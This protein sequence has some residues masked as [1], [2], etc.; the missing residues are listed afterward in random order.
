MA[1]MLSDRRAQN[2]AGN[3]PR[4]SPSD[5]MHNQ[6][7]FS[8]RLTVGRRPMQSDVSVSVVRPKFPARGTLLIRLPDSLADSEPAACLP[9][10]L[11]G[12][13]EAPWSA[14]FLCRFA[15]AVSHSKAP[16]DWRSPKNRRPRPAAGGHFRHKPL[17]AVVEGARPRAPSSP[18][19]AQHGAKRL[20]VRQSSAA[21]CR[22]CPIQSA[23]RL[24]QSKKLMPTSSRR[25]P[26]CPSAVGISVL[27]T[28][29]VAWSRRG[30]SVPNRARFFSA[31]QCEDATPLPR[32]GTV[33]R[34]FGSQG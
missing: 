5:C 4:R 18:L 21:L 33:T 27:R 12:T 28:E 29:E 32:K 26:P 17:I 2:N 8:A 9:S 30:P 10:G 20:G 1:R 6:W 3:P 24:A 34:Q 14:A 7:Q 23:M 25:R 13:R 22:P 16:E 15:L 31:I 19:S 11:A